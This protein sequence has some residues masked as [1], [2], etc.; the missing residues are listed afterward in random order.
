MEMGAHS[1]VHIL[2]ISLATFLALLSILAFKRVRRRQLFFVCLAFLLFA[3]REFIIFA[4]VVLGRNADNVLP[5]IEAPLSHALS[6]LIL[7]LFFLG[8]FPDRVV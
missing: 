6:L 7:L 2:I 8:V 5:F 4:E 3:A 1:L